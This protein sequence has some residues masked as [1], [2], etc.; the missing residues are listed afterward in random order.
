MKMKMCFSSIALLIV[1]VSSG[2]L[3]A[4]EQTS[5]WSSRASGF[6]VVGEGERATASI[7]SPDKNAELRVTG[8]NLRLI[9]KGADQLDLSRFLNTISLTEVLWS[10]DSSAFFINDSDG[11]SVGSW[12]THAYIVEN[13]E[14]I[15]IPLGSIISKNS[16]LT[17]D[18]KYKNVGSV[19]WIDGHGKILVIEQVPGSSGCSNMDSFAGY[20]IDVKMG[21][22]LEILG[23]DALK[24][25]FKKAVGANV[26]SLLRDE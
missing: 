19:T 12:E 5:L 22:V 7:M 18:C 26:K 3:A 9:V 6:N 10:D 15:E 11:G 13:R 2:S 23:P 4:E 24:K 1:L 21:K 17:S 20:I 8:D 25:R 14:V 16:R